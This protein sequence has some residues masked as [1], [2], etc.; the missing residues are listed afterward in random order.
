MNGGTRIW[1]NNVTELANVR[2]IPERGGPKVGV[3]I[4]QGHK[5]GGGREWASRA[6]HRQRGGD[7]KWG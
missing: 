6:T 4:S 5:G 2:E 3:M 1:G 7:P